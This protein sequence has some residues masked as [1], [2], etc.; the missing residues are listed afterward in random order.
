MHPSESRNAENTKSPRFHHQDGFA[1][2]S[3][4]QWEVGSWEHDFSRVSEKPFVRN[5]NYK[6]IKD[7]LDAKRQKSC[8]KIPIPKSCLQNSGLSLFAKRPVNPEF[9]N[10]G[11]AIT[12]HNDL[13]GP[14]LSD[15]RAS[16]ASEEQA[17]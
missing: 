4:A 5:K 14:A 1:T 10:F 12:S 3:S 9:R 8:N 7:A 16:S 15:T 2:R 6:P 17:D 11:I 13:S